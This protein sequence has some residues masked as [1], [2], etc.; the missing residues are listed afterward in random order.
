[1]KNTVYKISYTN[2]I[3]FDRQII[4]LKGR[5]YDKTKAKYNTKPS[6]RYLKEN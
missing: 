2:I 3:V 6:C 5:N 4:D 1:M